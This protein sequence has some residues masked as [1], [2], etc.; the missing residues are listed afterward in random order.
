MGFNFL[1]VRLVMLISK[2]VG[3]DSKKWKILIYQLGV[4]QT[5][6]SDPHDN[7]MNDNK[8]KRDPDYYYLYT[9]RIMRPPLPNNEV[10][11]L[12]VPHFLLASSWCEFI[13][14]SSSSTISPHAQFDERRRKWKWINKREAVK[15]IR[16]PNNNSDDSCLLGENNF[17]AKNHTVF[18][19]RERIC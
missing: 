16:I 14:A 5:V 10:F 18:I 19:L 3:Q 8:W 17:Q 7:D 4:A 1:R 6:F 12:L 13:L 9:S 11:N 2:W 15:R